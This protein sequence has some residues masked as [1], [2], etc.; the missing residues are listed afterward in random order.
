RRPG[1]G[2]CAG[3]LR[4]GSALCRT[5]LSRNALKR[6]WRFLSVSALRGTRCPQPGPQCRG[7]PE[8]DM[9]MATAS[10]GP[11]DQL[12]DL[13]RELL[14]LADRFREATLAQ[15]PEELERLARQDPALLVVGSLSLGLSLARS[16]GRSESRSPTERPH[17]WGHSPAH[18]E[19][20]A[21]D[22]ADEPPSSDEPVEAPGL[23]DLRHLGDTLHDKPGQLGDGQAGPGP[24]RTAEPQSPQSSPAGNPR[25]TLHDVQP[26]L[27]GALGVAAGALLAAL[28]PAAAE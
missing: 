22:T 10:S 14:E 28:Y 11:A 21:R 3:R 12:A 25:A 16:A 6:V 27:A 26:L 5:D 17:D 15:L 19:E 23:G 20:T 2:A 13:G 1:H 8:G 9:A 24:Q 7:R 4:P 18:H